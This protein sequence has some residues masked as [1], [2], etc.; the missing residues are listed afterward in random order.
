MVLV[1][2]TPM[3]SPN[4]PPMD[5]IMV[6]GDKVKDHVFFMDNVQSRIV[7]GIHEQGL[8]LVSKVLA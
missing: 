7:E 4:V 2:E 3:Q 5:P 1:Y 6:S 8:V